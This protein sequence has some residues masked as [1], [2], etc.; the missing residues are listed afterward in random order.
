M[1]N[2][3][4]SPR[5]ERSLFRLPKSAQRQVLAA[6]ERLRSFPDSGIMVREGRYR[7]TRRIVIRPHWDLYYRSVGSER[8]VILTAIRDSRRK[9]IYNKT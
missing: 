6:V 4:W 7:G 9:P 2:V 3:E 1:P 5:V 8:T